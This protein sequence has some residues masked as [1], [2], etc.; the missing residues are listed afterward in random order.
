MRFTSLSVACCFCLLA[1]SSEDSSSHGVAAS[2][3]ELSGIYQVTSHTENL[4]A[5]SEGAEVTAAGY[6]AVFTYDV[7]AF[8]ET[9]LG[10]YSCASEAACKDLA[11]KWPNGVSYEF[12]FTFTKGDR[13][14]LTASEVSTGYTS[15]EGLCSEPTQEAHRLLSVA[16]G[17]IR[18]ESEITVGDDY[19]GKDGF[20]TTDAASKAVQGKSCSRFVGINATQVAEL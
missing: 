16:D 8:G 4:D 20:C 19:Q 9:W 17:Q 11:A 2:A 5:C 1:C 6:L 3:Q 13:D 18:I 10:A 14:Q 7:P 12:G 15:A